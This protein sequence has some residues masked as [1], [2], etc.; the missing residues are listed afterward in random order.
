[1]KTKKSSK[2]L[3]LQKATV[4]DFIKGD[5]DN[6]KGGADSDPCVTRRYP[7]TDCWCPTDPPCFETF[8]C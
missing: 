3:H 2:K 7:Y 1:M 4:S 6:V 8:P 5:L